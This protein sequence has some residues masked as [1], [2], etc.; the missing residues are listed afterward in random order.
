VYPALIDITT[1]IL[2]DFKAVRTEVILAG[3]ELGIDLALYMTDLNGETYMGHTQILE[4]PLPPRKMLRAVTQN[5]HALQAACPVPWRFISLCVDTWHT[6]NN[7][8]WNRRSMAVDHATNFASTVRK[9]LSVF[10]IDA[11]GNV[12]LAYAAYTIGDDGLPAWDD[13]K[14]TANPG[15]FPQHALVFA[16]MS[17]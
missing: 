12:L 4:R 8:D 15:G 6:P 9:G 5:V 11:E 16:T 1:S 7:D 10:T 3:S 17:T 13:T 2:E 14:V